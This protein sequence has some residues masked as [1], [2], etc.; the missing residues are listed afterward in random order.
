MK[1]GQSMIGGRLIFCAAMVLMVASWG[2]ADTHY[3]RP[4]S[5]SPAA[6]YTNWAAAASNIQ[7]AVN[8]SAA[9][10]TVLA[11]NGTYWLTNQITI[12]EAV[13]V[14]SVN[15]SANTIVNGNYPSRT[16]RCILA[17]NANALVQGFTIT[18]GFVWGYGGGAY[19]QN[20]ATVRNCI[21]SGNRS[22]DGSGGGVC[23][24]AAGTVDLCSVVGNVA[25]GKI[26]GGGGIFLYYG[27]TVTN[28]AIAW[29]AAYITNSSASYAGGGGVYLYQGG[30]VQNCELTSNRLNQ[31]AVDG[32][33]GGAAI[34]GSAGSVINSIISGNT[35]NIRGGGVYIISGGTLQ[36]CLIKENKSPTT[37]SGLCLY[38]NGN[39]RNCT[40]VNNRGS[41][42]GWYFYGGST[43]GAMLENCIIVS[44]YGYTEYTLNN[45]G[46]SGTTLTNLSITNTCTYPTNFNAGALRSGC[47]SNNPAFAGY[48]VG[49]YRLANNSPCVNT[50]TNQSW[51][52][53]AS[54]I[55]GRM[56]IRYGVVD[57]GAY[58]RIHEATV[59]RFY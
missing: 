31:A 28:S 48:S 17:T 20:G 11:T 52:E 15:G 23:I 25:T 16:N 1:A 41:T 51:M 59:Y 30:L 22:Q 33:G 47:I 58:E 24:N 56:R 40:I 3:V 19:L 32:G 4:D 38:Y 21:I 12:G 46:M 18:N 10:D 57:M 5:P 13:T 34:W 44:N 2:L 55:D 37:G 36:G 49:N 54:D 35:N 8:A 9:G 27:G 53:N 6:P 50:G 45:W 26:N 7:D 29:N 39:I 42:P 43:P 14:M